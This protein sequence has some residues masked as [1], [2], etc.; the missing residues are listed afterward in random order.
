M[1]VKADRKAAEELLQGAMGKLPKKKQRK[2]KHEEED[3]EDFFSEDGVD[4][5]EEGTSKPSMPVLSPDVELM[6]TIRA[7]V[8]KRSLAMDKQDEEAEARKQAAK[9]RWEH[10]MTTRKAEAEALKE[11]AAGNKALADAMVESNKAMAT[12]MVDSMKAMAET[13]AAKFTT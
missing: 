4:E 11:S 3:E 6:Q 8:E 7:L 9:D 10:E 5:E 1:V 13:I 2:K 12:A